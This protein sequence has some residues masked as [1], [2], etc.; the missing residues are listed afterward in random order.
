ML[1]N[2]LIIFDFVS[3]GIPAGVYTRGYYGGG[4][5]RGGGGGES[6]EETRS[7][8]VS[9]TVSTQMSFAVH[10]MVC[11]SSTAVWCASVRCDAVCCLSPLQCGEGGNKD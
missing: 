2:V 6:G 9:P 10:A 8:C 3:F 5:T 11:C 1:P 7:N 4:D